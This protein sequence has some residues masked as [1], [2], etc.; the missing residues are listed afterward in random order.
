MQSDIAK[1]INYPEEMMEMGIQGKVYV[2]FV[3]EKD[4]SI[5]NVKV[6]RGINGARL[7][8]EEAVRAVMKLPKKFTPGKMNGKPV[9][10][11]LNVPV[12]FQLK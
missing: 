5:T 6:I 10:V 9:R 7:L 11:A 3:V 2:S 4:G 1:N 8:G 12:H